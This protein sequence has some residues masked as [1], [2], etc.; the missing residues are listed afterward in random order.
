MLQLLLVAVTGGAAESVALVLKEEVPPAPVGAP[1]TAPVEA[2]RFKPV[3]SDPAVTK[4]LKGAVPPVAASEELYAT[5]TMAPGSGQ[6]TA[7]S[8]G[9]VEVVIGAPGLTIVLE[10]NVTAPVR[11][12]ALPFSM[13]PVLAVIDTWARMVPLKVEVVPRVAELPTCQKMLAAFAPLMRTT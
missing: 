3:G 2:F 11:A 4:K 5:P 12:N 1:V 7:V 10:S 8:A 6:V 9:G 13:A